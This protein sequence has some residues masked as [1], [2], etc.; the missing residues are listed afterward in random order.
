METRA[1]LMSIFNAAKFSLHHYA[2]GYYPVD[3]RQKTTRPLNRIFMPLRN[4]NGEENY[5]EEEGK[6]HILIPGMLYY[7]PPFLPTEF[8]LDD[9]LYFLSIQNNVEIFPGVELFSGCS[10]M[11]VIP[12]P[13]QVDE[14]LA[15]MDADRKH[16]YM[17]AMRAGNLIFSIQAQLMTY[18]SEEEFWKPLALQEFAS[19]T[20]YLQAYGNARTSVSDLAALYHCSRENF[21]RHFTQKTGLTPKQLIDRFVINRCLSLISGGHSIKE[22]A[23]LLE[24]SNEFVFSRYFKRN[25]GEAPSHWLKRRTIHPQ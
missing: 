16:V 11:T 2:R 12:N 7:V 15:L 19:L 18:Y 13:P 5:I 24:F 25:M 6:R 14:L 4:P 10:H 9:E 21:T 8:R 22:T 3:V 23:D 17:D 1:D 20:E